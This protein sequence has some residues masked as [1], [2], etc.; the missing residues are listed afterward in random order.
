VA[1]E[2]FFRHQNHMGLEGNKDYPRYLDGLKRL[3]TVME[4][5]RGRYFRPSSSPNCIA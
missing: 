4:N 5:G 3:K 1:D 2:H